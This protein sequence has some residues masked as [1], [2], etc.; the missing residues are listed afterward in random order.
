MPDTSASAGSTCTPFRHP[1]RY[2]RAT[3]TTRGP[4]PFQPVAREGMAVLGVQLAAPRP[5]RWGAISLPSVVVLSPSRASPASMPAR[6][7]TGVNKGLTGVS[8][9]HASACLGLAGTRAPHGCRTACGGQCSYRF[10]L[11]CLGSSRALGAGRL[12]SAVGGQGG[13]AS[14]KKSTR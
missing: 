5:P 1:V 11:S 4:T 3:H 6:K 8:Q 12:A 9:S 14:T 2:Q 7:Q 10:L 13:T